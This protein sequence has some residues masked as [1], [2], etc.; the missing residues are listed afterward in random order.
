MLV[1]WLDCE[2]TPVLFDGTVLTLTIIDEGAKDD[3]CDRPEELLEKPEIELPLLAS[4]PKVGAVVAD[5][6]G[7]V[8]DC[9]AVESDVGREVMPFEDELLVVVRSSVQVVVVRARVSRIV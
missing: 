6:R 4:V 7:V 3:A 8:K 1:P 2:M 9:S 5:V